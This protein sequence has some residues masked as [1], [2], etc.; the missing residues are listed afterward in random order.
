V[1]PNHRRD[2]AVGIK[3][4]ALSLPVGTGDRPTG[5]CFAALTSWVNRISRVDGIQSVARQF[6]VLC[7]TLRSQLPPFGRFLIHRV[8]VT[9]SPHLCA[10]GNRLKTVDKRHLIFTKPGKEFCSTIEFCVNHRQPF[11]LDT[12]SE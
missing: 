11:Q 5:A 10:P 12:L 8:M 6:V 1:W 7:G 4:A 2:N 9:D 3:P